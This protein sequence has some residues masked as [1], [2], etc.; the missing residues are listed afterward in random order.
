MQWMRVQTERNRTRRRWDKGKEGYEGNAQDTTDHSLLHCRNVH[1]I[2]SSPC[3]HSMS[4]LAISHHYLWE[5]NIY[6]DLYIYL[7]IHWNCHMA[8]LTT[9]HI[10]MV[11]I[12]IH[13][14]KVGICKACWV[15]CSFS[16]CAPGFSLHNAVLPIAATRDYLRAQ[17][18]PL[19]Q[20]SVHYSSLTCSSNL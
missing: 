20:F 1:V 12:S 4:F 8:M 16:S 19:S 7:Y 11:K 9:L 17:L 10:I 5:P 6:F 18:H 14:L 15:R 13:G 2:S 3:F